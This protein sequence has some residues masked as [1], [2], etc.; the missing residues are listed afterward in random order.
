MTFFSVN[1]FRSVCVVGLLLGALSGCGGGTDKWV[2]GRE[3]VNPVSGIVTLDGKPVEGAV[4][5]F[6]SA[7]KP[8]SAQGLTDASGQYHLTT[9]E[10]H[11]GA[12]AGEHKV[13]VR[14]TEYKEV[15]SGNWTE[16]EPAMIKQSVELLPIEYATEKTTTLKKSVPEGG[17]QDLNIEL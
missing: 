7:S 15:K 8:I 5:M 11:D 14:K 13:T 16:E 9:Y 1:K 17:A 12:V 3:K 6:I 10:Q 4:V 2:E